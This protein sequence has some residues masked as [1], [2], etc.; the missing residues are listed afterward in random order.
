MAEYYR[1]GQQSHSGG[2][3][4]SLHTVQDVVMGGATLLLEGV[5]TAV[6]LFRTS[7]RRGGGGL[8]RW[9]RYEILVSLDFCY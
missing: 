4:L 8:Y 2:R 5:E 9:S 6:T 7:L 3:G 1:G